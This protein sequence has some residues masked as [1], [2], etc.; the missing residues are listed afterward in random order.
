MA[1]A[2]AVATAEAADAESGGTER[3]RLSCGDGCAAPGRLA[4]SQ[5]V[6]AVGTVAGA[7]LASAWIAGLGCGADIGTSCI[8]P[9][10]PIDG[11]TRLI[12][13]SILRF[14][15]ERR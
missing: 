9:V 5:C 13:S 11:I 14:F 10:A 6:G 2:T 3:V 12:A 15:A 1:A 7:S 8:G 4:A